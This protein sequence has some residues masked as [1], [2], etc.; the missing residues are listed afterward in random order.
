MFLFLNHNINFDNLESTIQSE[1]TIEK[2]KSNIEKY[3]KHYDTIYL[4][5]YLLKIINIQ[6]LSIN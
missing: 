4:L 5:K 1:L 2:I 3:Y 6:L